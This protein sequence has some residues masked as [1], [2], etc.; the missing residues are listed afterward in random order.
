MDFA[1]SIDHRVKKK[2]KKTVHHE[3]DGGTNCS[4]YTWN[5]HQRFG[6]KA[7]GIGNLER[8]ETIQTSA[9]L[10]SARIP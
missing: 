4:W 10:R 2:P 8:I 5:G 6:K 9:L 3:G 1:V 7:E